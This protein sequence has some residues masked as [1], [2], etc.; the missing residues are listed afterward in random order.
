MWPS[1]FIRSDILMKI[2]SSNGYAPIHRMDYC[3]FIVALE[4][5][6][7]FQL[8]SICDWK[9]LKTVDNRWEWVRK[10]LS[11]CSGLGVLTDIL[12]VFVGNTSP[13]NL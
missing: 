5:R 10:Y 8:D 3:W 4:L 9:V 2:G 6:N 12:G 11:F 7:A 1:N 13:T